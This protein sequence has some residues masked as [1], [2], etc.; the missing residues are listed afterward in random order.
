MAGCSDEGEL[1]VGGALRL[2]GSVTARGGIAGGGTDGGTDG[3]VG[4]PWR[5]GIAP[6]AAAR[7]LRRRHRGIPSLISRAARTHCHCQPAK[8]M[9]RSIHCG[10]RIGIDSDGAHCRP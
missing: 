9:R 2:A 4:R 5:H 7:N 3:G 1:G 10:M 6:P 8:Q